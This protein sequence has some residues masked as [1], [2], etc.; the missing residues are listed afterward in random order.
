MEKIELDILNLLLF[1]E[2][3]HQLREEAVLFTT[4]HIMGDV[5]KGLMHRGYVFALLPNKEG[6]L[7]RVLGFDS[8]ALSEYSFQLSAKGIRAL[9]NT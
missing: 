2:S 1:P 5:I 6:A 8:D 7:K 4:E 9:T 3:Y